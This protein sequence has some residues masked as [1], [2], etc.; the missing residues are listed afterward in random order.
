MDPN[1][2]Q[3]LSADD[4]S[5]QKIIS[6]SPVHKIT[7][8]SVDPDQIAFFMPPTLNKLKGHIATG[9]CPPS[10]CASVTKMKFQF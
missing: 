9:I 2:L 7:T 5:R 3:M 8:N 6:S 1:Y 4:T 10:V